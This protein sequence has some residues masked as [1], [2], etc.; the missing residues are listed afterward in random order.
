MGVLGIMGAMP[1]EID[2]LLPHLAGGSATV[3]AG[4]RFVRGRLW[5]QDA[6]VVFSRWGKVAA[7][8]TAT[9]LIVRHGVERI[10]F[11]GIAG[12]LDPGLAPGDVVVARR[13]V[14]HDLDASPFFPPGVVPLLGVREFVAD[15]AMSEGLLAAAESFLLARRRGGACTTTRADGARARAVRA[16]V[17][18]GDRVI[19]SREDA[20]GVLS[21]VPGAA[22][23]EM[24][25]AAVAQVCF[26]HSVPFAC[27]RT[28]SDAA[29]HAV[30]ESV[31]P[32]FE[33]LAGEYAVGILSRWIGTG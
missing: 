32:F 8:S 10:V 24:E 13:L 29:D 31:R 33:G 14:Q 25:G 3:H 18:S 23:V 19:A 17:A 15:E 11:V 6:A 20:R 4:R 28:I 1:E 30:V 27:V 7:A 21:C 16:D 12:A 5:G 22:C 9:E 26:E 2:A